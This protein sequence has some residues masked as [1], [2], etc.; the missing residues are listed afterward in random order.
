MSRAILILFCLGAPFAVSAQQQSEGMSRAPW[1]S[2]QLPERPIEARICSCRYA[3]QNIPIGQTICMKFEGKR[4][5]ATCDTV[6]NNPS[7]S[8]SSEVCPS[9]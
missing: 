6:V 3:G 8:I 7:W 4:V 9:T 1:P 5:R 2:Q